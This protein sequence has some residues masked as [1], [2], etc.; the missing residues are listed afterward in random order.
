M[1][2]T[3]DVIIVVDDYGSVVEVHSTFPLKYS[4]FQRETTGFAVGPVKSNEKTG[5]Y[6]QLLK[7]LGIE[8][9]TTKE[10]DSSLVLKLICK[11]SLLKKSYERAGFRA[12]DIKRILSAE[13]M[14]ISPKCNA[15]LKTIFNAFVK[16][17]KKLMGEYIEIQQT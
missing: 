13:S 17:D 11:N 1:Q 2:E 16:A 7:N 9:Q 3:P 10:F 8:V 4:V 5:T 15:H 12:D 14:V 6:K